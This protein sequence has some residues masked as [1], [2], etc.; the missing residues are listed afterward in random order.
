MFTL[1]Y[2]YFLYTSADTPSEDVS[3]VLQAIVDGKDEITAAIPAFVW[4]DLSR[5]G[6]IEG[7]SLHQGAKVA[8]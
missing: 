8:D 2:D 4:F 1:T 3:S 7:L 6:S 5:S